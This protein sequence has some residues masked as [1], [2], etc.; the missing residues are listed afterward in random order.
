M[1]IMCIE[2]VDKSKTNSVCKIM[3]KNFLK[4]AVLPLVN[5]L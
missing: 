5:V 1:W 3:S 2:I 4:C